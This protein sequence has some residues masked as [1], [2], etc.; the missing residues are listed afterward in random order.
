V[1]VK[2]IRL[3]GSNASNAGRVEVNIAGIWGT[4]RNRGWDMNASNVACRQLGYPGAE[5][6]ILSTVGPYGKGVGPVWMS[7]LDCEGREDSLWKCSWPRIA[8]IYWD[9][10]NDAGVICKIANSS[11]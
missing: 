2:E 3:A 7:D 11:K 5:A 1:I 8:G 6:A 4:I 10:D 9:H